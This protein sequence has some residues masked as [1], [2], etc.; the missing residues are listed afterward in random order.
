MNSRLH[1][2]LGHSHM[3]FSKFLLEC[4]SW[5]RMEFDFSQCNPWGKAHTEIHAPDSKFDNA[6]PRTHCTQCHL[7]GATSSLQDTDT[8]HVPDS[9][10]NV[11]TGHAKH[12]KPSGD[13]YF[14][15]RQGMQYDALQKSCYSPWGTVCTQ[16][17]CSACLSIGQLCTQCRRWHVR[18]P[19]GGVFADT[20]GPCSRSSLPISSPLDKVYMPWYRRRGFLI[21][22]PSCMT[23]L[24]SLYGT[25]LYSC[26]IYRARKECTL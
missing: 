18:R 1:L 20:R 23:C 22:I 5:T 3:K 2:P 24:M 19:Q 7:H 21:R 15:G 10:E 26:R 8:R 11:S 12:V 13:W 6:R 14:P 16:T 4:A 25:A 9:S 17:R